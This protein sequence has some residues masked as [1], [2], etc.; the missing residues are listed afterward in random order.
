MKSGE[1][2]RILS[3]RAAEY[4]KGALR[5]VRK[6]SHMN[7]LDS[8]DKKLIETM[9]EFSQKLAEAVLA[10][11]LNF[12]GVGFGLDSGIYTKHFEEDL[13]KLEEK[14]RKTKENRP[15]RT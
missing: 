8:R 5:S 14:K 15:E 7:D 4:H 2:M 12:V 13:R 11:F 6:N 3:E 1:Y 9:P 10:D